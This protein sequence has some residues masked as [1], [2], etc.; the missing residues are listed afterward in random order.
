[1]NPCGGTLGVTAL[2]NLIAE[3]LTDEELELLLL[4]ATQFKITI[5]NI[6]LA[7][8][9]IK[10]RGNLLGPDVPAPSPGPEVPGRGT[11]RTRRRL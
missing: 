1:M 4:S 11:Q 9:V 7:R 6:L 3:G 5:E 2:A 8:A 10:R